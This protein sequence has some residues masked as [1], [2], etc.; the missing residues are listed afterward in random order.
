[1]K[2]IN[3]LE[4]EHIMYACNMEDM[5]PEKEW[6]HHSSFA[7]TGCGLCSAVMVADRLL[8][9]PDFTIK[10]ALQLAYETGANHAPGT[11]YKLFAPAF[12]EKMGLRLLMTSDM[13]DVKRCVRT[14]GAVVANSGG[15]R[16]GW[17]G[18]YTHGGHYVVVISET[19]DGRLCVLD[20]SLREDKFNEEGRVG[21]VEVAGKFTYCEPEI[22]RKD[23]ENRTPSFY[24]FWRR[25]P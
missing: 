16:E 6:L 2:Y 3:Q 24:C 17:T 4:N 15:D 18:V 22:L 19:E 13:E 12:A 11:D 25:E 21:K 5:T 14:G 20:P 23:T 10:D 7:K 1:M 9:D 8:I